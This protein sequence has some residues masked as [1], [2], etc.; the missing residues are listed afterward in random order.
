MLTPCEKGTH[1]S[2]RRVSPLDHVRCTT[3]DVG[4]CPVPWISPVVPCNMGR[5]TRLK[6]VSVV[7]HVLYHFVHCPHVVA[8]ARDVC[9]LMQMR[10]W[11]QPQFVQC[12]MIEA[13]SRIPTDRLS[14]HL[15]NCP[16][17]CQHVVKTVLWILCEMHCTLREIHI[18]VF[19]I[20]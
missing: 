18:L 20:H 14:F 11:T 12:L 6:C 8:F 4:P 7:F 2:L 10:V 16:S 3:R 17:I 5:A 9:T 19:G 13:P 15:T 1:V